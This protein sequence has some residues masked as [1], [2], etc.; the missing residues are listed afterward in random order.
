MS[1]ERSIASRTLRKG[2]SL[3][4]MICTLATLAP[5][6]IASSVGSTS[7]AI[8][9]SFPLSFVRL[10]SDVTLFHFQSE[11]SPV[12]GN[13]KDTVAVTA[14]TVL[15]MPST[16]TFTITSG[17]TY[18]YACVY[19]K[20]TLY[21]VLASSIPAAMSSTD[22]ISYV[23]GTLWTASTFVSMKVEYGIKRDVSVYGLQLA[24]QT[25][26]YYSD[27]LDGSY[28]DG[29]ASAVKKFQRDYKLDVDGYAGPYTQ[30]VL[31]PL[32]ANAYTSSGTTVGTQVGSLTT[33]ANVNLR[34]SASTKS[35]KK[36]VVPKKTTLAYTKTTTASGVTW[37]YVTYGKYT[38]WLMG[39]YAST[40]GSS[41]SS[42]GGTE[43]NLGTVTITMTNTRVR[44]TANGTKSGYV[45]AKGTT[46]TLLTSPTSA[47][48]YT[49]YYIKTSTGIKGY[50]RGD[51]ATVS[52]DAGGG[53][54]PSTTKTYVRITA[55]AGITLFTSEE[56]S[57]TGAVTVG[58]GTVLQM[59]STDT[60]TK[61]S[62]VYCSVYYNNKRYNC[63]YASLSSDIM[64]AAALTTYITGTI[65]PAGYSAAG[66]LKEALSLTGNVYVHSL[67]YALSLLGY[68][69]GTLDGNFG[70]ATT[71][72]V[73]NFQKAYKQTVDGSVGPET[74]AALY[75]AAIA[76][77]TGGGTTSGDFGTVTAVK[78]GAWS[79]GDSGGAIF[80]KYSTAKIMDLSTKKVFS[81][82]RWY[83]KNHAD[84]VPSTAADTKIMCDIIGFPYNSSHPSSS[85]LSQIIKDSNNS[86]NPSGTYIWPD[87]KGS[88]TTKTWNSGAWDR[89][90]ALINIG[91]TVY[92]VSIYGW[93]H[94]YDGEDSICKFASTNNFYGMM[95]V[96]FNGSKTHVGDSI[97]SLHMADI[98]EAYSYA[99][100]KWPSLVKN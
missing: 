61:N 42:G 21:N 71:S 96:H 66:T 89:R 67:Q 83:G 72:A 63:L 50:V 41:G 87:F 65:W 13:I 81:I 26:G 15:M 33:T 58:K 45:L 43:S 84:C 88:W 56:A 30:K 80:P 68:Y 77:L 70:S 97:D 73:R 90:A 55:D 94:G 25:L 48:G 9:E 60:Y 29:T 76:A 17:G 18:E 51:C 75:P 64:S 78:L 35:V 14:G 47:G 11:S 7:A 86:S 46:A 4:L 53:V 39:T 62:Q 59:V 69:T 91:G 6:A 37:Y 95:C 1:T 98:S 22:V 40:S 5:A 74:S 20:N 38:G 23:T 31:Y 32:A 10:A 28:G 57:S 24:L 54:T 44:K 3:L 100:S 49:W 8:T 52:Y 92:P 12:Y 79:F 2:I 82:Y 93:P 99:K 27:T 34:K 85:Q 19:Y 36:A 16:D